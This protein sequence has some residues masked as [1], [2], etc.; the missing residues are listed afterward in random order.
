MVLIFKNILPTLLDQQRHQKQNLCECRLKT[1]PNVQGGSLRKHS[2]SITNKQTEEE[3][4]TGFQ[5][6]M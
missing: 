4:D 3:L 5:W 1:L 6:D 2:F